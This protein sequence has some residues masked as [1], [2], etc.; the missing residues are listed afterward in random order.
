MKII[1]YPSIF[2]IVT[3]IAIMVNFFFTIIESI[4][5]Q[6][7]DTISGTCGT[8]EDHNTWKSVG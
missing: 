3:N 5:I 7:K 4:E 6:N 1:K 2:V 8:I